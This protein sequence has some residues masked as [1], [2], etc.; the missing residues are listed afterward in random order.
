MSA[1]LRRLKRLE[2]IIKNNRDTKNKKP[3]E[4][5]S[6]DM[7]LPKAGK[8]IFALARIAMLRSLEIHCG[9]PPLIDHSPTDKETTIALTEISQGKVV[10]KNNNDCQSI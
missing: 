8:S 10:L 6:L 1:L 7:L 2:T 3:L 5:I 4:E 9:S